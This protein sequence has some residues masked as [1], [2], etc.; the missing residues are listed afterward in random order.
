MPWVIIGDMNEILYSFEKEGGNERQERFMQAFRE[1]LEDGNLSDHGY[2]GDKFTW[3][4]GLIRERLD[5]ALVNEGWNLMFL[6]AKL[7]HLEYN[8][9]IT[10]PY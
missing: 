8:D 9:L 5:R 6:L 1:T 10:D 4:R 3:H 2:T 7:E